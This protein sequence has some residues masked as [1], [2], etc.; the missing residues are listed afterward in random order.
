VSKVI[1]GVGWLGFCCLFLLSVNELIEDQ[2]M[3]TEVWAYLL[4]M[5]LA[6]SLAL[7]S[8]PFWLKKNTLQNNHFKEENLVNE[9]GEKEAPN[10]EEKGFDIPIM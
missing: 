9:E 10:P 4:L 7:S 5:P 6:L 1:V 2:T 3:T 8:E